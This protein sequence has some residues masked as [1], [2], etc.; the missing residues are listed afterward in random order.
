M[1]DIFGVPVVAMQEDEGAG[2][3]A[4]IQAAWAWH[5]LDQ[6]QAKLAP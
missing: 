4:A 6:A 1:A 3:G 5:R 2:L